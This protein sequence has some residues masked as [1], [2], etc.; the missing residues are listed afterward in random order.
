MRPLRLLTSYRLGD[1]LSKKCASSKESLTCQDPMSPNPNKP[2][3]IELAWY[4]LAASK[5]ETGLIHLASWFADRLLL[6][7]LERRFCL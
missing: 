1:P 3:E 4:F 6:T 7:L 2:K 5:I